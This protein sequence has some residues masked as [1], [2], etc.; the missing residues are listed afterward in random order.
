MHEMFGRSQKAVQSD[1][2]G[3]ERC[4]VEVTTCT[5]VEGPRE[6]YEDR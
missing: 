2:T 6:R 4:K 3:A 1:I 5:A